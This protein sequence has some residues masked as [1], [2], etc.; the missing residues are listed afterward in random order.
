MLSNLKQFFNT[1]LQSLDKMGEQDSETALK[2]AAAVLFVEV[3]HADHQV[4][5]VEQQAVCQAISKTFDLTET[6]AEELFQLAEERVRDVTSLHEFTS[7]INRVFTRE[8]KVKLVEQM[9]VVVFSDNELD[10][11]EEH[12]VRRT[13]ELLYVKHSDFIRAKHNALETCEKIKAR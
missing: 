5:D 1:H 4:Q 7:L 3:M 2:L 11:H 13:A 9:W 8:Q 6:E 12:L 10:S